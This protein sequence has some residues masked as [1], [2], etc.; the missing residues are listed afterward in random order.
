MAIKVNLF[1]KPQTI[2]NDTIYKDIDLACKVGVPNNENITD[3][4][5]DKDLLTSINFNAIRNSFINLMTTSPGEKILSPTF[6]VSFG[7]LLF[8]PISKKI[9]KLIAEN[10][11]DKFVQF[12][13]R[14][15]IEKFDIVA[16]SEEN[17]YDIDILF[18]IPDFENNPLNLKGALSKSG[19][20]TF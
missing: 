5:N 3:S 18:I 13:P 1:E 11:L 19:F 16:N 17:Q 10:I 4:E 2:I 12:E 8:L 9:A 7:D 20:Y 6:G 14:I 15:N